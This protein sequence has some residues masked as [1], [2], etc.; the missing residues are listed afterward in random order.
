MNSYIE[1]KQEIEKLEKR[2]SSKNQERNDLLLPLFKLIK[3]NSLN[4]ILPSNLDKYNPK[5]LPLRLTILSE[6]VEINNLKD[7]EKIL[8]EIEDI[9]RKIIDKNNEQ[10]IENQRIDN[11]RIKLKERKEYVLSRIPEINN[12][13]KQIEKLQSGID[14]RLK[15]L[16][17]GSLEKEE[18]RVIREIINKNIKQVKELET[19]KQL[20]L[21]E[22]GLYSDIKQIEKEDNLIKQEDKKDNEEQQDNEFLKKAKNINSSL[23]S[24]EDKLSE[25]IQTVD[26]EPIVTEEQ[27][28]KIDIPFPVKQENKVDDK[29]LQNNKP[30]SFEIEEIK[31]DTP[32]NIEVEKLL[33]QPKNTSQEL[34]VPTSD[35]LTVVETHS[36]FL[37]ETKLKLKKG[38]RIILGLK[39]ITAQKLLEIKA[40]A[41]K[42][43]T[44]IG[45]TISN[46]I[47]G[48]VKTPESKIV[49]KARENIEVAKQLLEENKDNLSEEETE[50]IKA[51]LSRVYLKLNQARNDKTHQRYDSYYQN[52]A[53]LENISDQ[54]SDNVTAQY[55]K[56]KAR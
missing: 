49:D 36:N 8:S 14:R 51:N 13:D 18:Q 28:K 38:L 54:L 22:K 27:T 53:E 35:D 29:P 25:K 48:I 19:R 45:D 5:N 33:E 43:N 31:E 39:N 16:N 15:I 50:K 30:I 10:I 46:L 1:I 6:E 20:I 9:K 40:K 37:L 52:I 41:E 42:K 17:E 34:T 23:N 55:N 24:I 2:L 26:V 21:N 12:I 47:G 11:M 32:N 7:K 44:N 56:I 3:E 4:N